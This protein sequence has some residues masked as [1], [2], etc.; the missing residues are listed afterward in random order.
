MAI[1][2]LASACNG[3]S[4]QP[5]EESPEVSASETVLVAHAPPGETS[6]RV[7]AG[8]TDGNR[9]VEAFMPANIRIRAGDTIEWAAHGFEGHTVTFGDDD[10]I[11]ATIGDYLVPNPENPTEAMF[12]PNLS[13]PSARQGTHDG[14]DAFINS[15]FF[16][17]PVEQLYSLTFEEPGLYSYVCLVHPF[18]MTGTVA[19]EETGTQVESPEAML[20]RADEEREQYLAELAEEARRVAAA[21]T[22]APGPGDARTH[23]VQVGVITDH[24][25]MAVYLPGLLEVDAGDTVIFQND[26]RNFHNVVFKGAQELPPGIGIVPDPGGRGLN[27]TLSNASAV[28]V[29]PPPEGFDPSTFLSSGSMGVTQPRITWTLRFTTPGT[30]VYACTIHTQAGMTG[31]IEVK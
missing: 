31:V 27:F 6:F 22:S 21:T 11:F 15:G 25:Q 19:V 24:G 3:D 10:D 7:L 12:N 4:D 23:Y 17:V 8:A 9:D 28:A 16:G 30:Y 18:T 2:L 20:A 26:D 5:A 29:D 14:N 1:A 13:L